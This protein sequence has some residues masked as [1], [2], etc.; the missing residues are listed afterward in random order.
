MM[1]GIGTIFDVIS[2]ASA[3]MPSL[4]GKGIKIVRGKSHNTFFVLGHYLPEYAGEKV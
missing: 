3:F 2:S 1:N 4:I